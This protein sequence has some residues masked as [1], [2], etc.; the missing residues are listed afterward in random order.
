[1]NRETLLSILNAWP[2]PLPDTITTWSDIDWNKGIDKDYIWIQ[3][4]IPAYSSLQE[5]CH[6]QVLRPLNS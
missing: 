2:N 1:M 6:R 3:N 4:I 5:D